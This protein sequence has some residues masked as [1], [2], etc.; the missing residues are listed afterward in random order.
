MTPVVMSGLS[1]SFT[2]DTPVKP[3]S[4]SVGWQTYYGG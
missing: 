1:A 2:I 3:N 4:V